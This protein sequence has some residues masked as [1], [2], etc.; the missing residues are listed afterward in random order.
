MLIKAKQEKMIGNYYYKE[1]KKLKHYQ[2]AINSN[3]KIE[4]DHNVSGVLGFSSNK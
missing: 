3:K 4:K 2:C 1:K